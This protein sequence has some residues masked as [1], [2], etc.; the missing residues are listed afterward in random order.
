MVALV[1]RS[2]TKAALS[3]AAVALASRVAVL[4][5]SW[6]NFSV[7]LARASS[8]LASLAVLATARWT[9]VLSCDIAVRSSFTLP[10]AVTRSVV[11]TLNFRLSNSIFLNLYNA[12]GAT[13][14]LG[15]TLPST[16][17]R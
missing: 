7:F 13:L 2:V 17:Q 16:T 10:T 9:G 3:L 14:S 11:S 6:F 15:S 4:A 1:S 12:L 5:F 8:S